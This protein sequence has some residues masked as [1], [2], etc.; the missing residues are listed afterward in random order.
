MKKRLARIYLW[1]IV[2]TLCMAILAIGLA[3]FFRI[4]D[5]RENLYS[6]LQTAVEWTRD[7]NEDLESLAKKIASVSPPLRVTFMMEEGLMLADSWEGANLQRNH[8]G[9]PEIS[10]ARAGEVGRRLFYSPGRNTLFLYLAKQVSPGL[11]LRVSYPVLEVGRALLGYGSLMAALFLLLYL[12]QRRMLGRFGME[13]ES[14]FREIRSLLEGEKEKA[15]AVFPEFAP[16]LEA[17]SY[18]FHRLREDRE[19][20][21]R[22]MNLRADFVA[23]ASH[24][25]R[26]PLTSIRGFAEMLKE[27]MA[28]SEE[29]RQLCLEM[30][31]GECDRMLEV[32]EDVLSLRRAE[33]EEPVEQKLLE[34]F[35]LAQEVCLS[36]TPLAREKGIQLSISGEMRVYCQEKDLWEILFNLISNAIT[37]GKEGGFVN[38]HLEEGSLFVSD[39]GIGISP[40]DA[41]LVFEPFYRADEA[42]GEGGTGLGLSI[43]KALA[44]RMGA[45][46]WLESSLG[47][48][49]TFFLSF[50]EEVK[51]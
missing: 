51:S 47:E 10:A 50:P 1:E 20:I 9:D 28:S 45:S 4:S 18:Q 35:P 13:L 11:I 15:R 14:Q 24:E 3:L 31:V 5:I 49:S 42:R 2:F 37:Y 39:N 19:E 21:L 43:V 34:V 25:L 22:T 33:K 8:Y 48:G 7:S 29:E 17:I 16:S 26:S 32:I 41:K 44:K 46:I 27:D 23:H 30:I 12:A 36:L 6:S 40:E 38:V